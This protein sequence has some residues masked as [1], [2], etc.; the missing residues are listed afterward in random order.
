MNKLEQLKQIT[1]VV[2]DT[3][4]IEAIKIL[5]FYQLGTEQ[6]YIFDNN[7]HELNELHIKMRA[8]EVKMK[9]L[10]IDPYQTQIDMD[11]LN[12]FRESNAH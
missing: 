4:D 8:L 6:M 3:G 9:T 2:A 12:A 5:R 1:T 7:D 10:D 11:S